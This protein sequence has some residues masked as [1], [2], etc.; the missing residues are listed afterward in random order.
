MQG[1][2]RRS[3]SGDRVSRFVFTLNNYS[4]PEYNYLV[5]DFAPTVKWMCIGKEVGSNG[6]PHLQGACILGTQMAFSK[7]KILI[8]FRRA[9]IETMHGRPED[10]LIYCSKEDSAPFVCG[11]LP[12]PGK[13]TDVSEAVSRIRTGESLRE[14]ANDDSGGIAVVKFFK[15]L[16]VLRSLIRPK[17][18]SQPDV[19]WFFGATGLGKTRMAYKCG[20]AICRATG[21]ATSDIWISSGGLRWFDGYDGQRVA[22]FDDFRNKHCPNFA[23]FLRLLDR[24]P[25]AVEFKGGMV[26]WTPQFIFITCPYDP[27]RCFQKRGEH[28]PEDMAQLKRRT[29]LVCDFS[30]GSRESKQDRQDFVKNVLGECHGLREEPMVLEVTEEPG[31][32]Q[33]EHGI[34]DPG[35]SSFGTD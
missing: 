10:S 14:L 35:D 29:T 13:R 21:A 1:A 30:E 4:P 7:L 2:A 9:H 33:G 24:Y 12:T 11:T 17:R 32:N 19:F 16:T 20:R 23:F 28:V 22:I 25:V 26:E 5:N 18:S 6:T 15:G 8:G 3:R 34:P 27:I 31:I